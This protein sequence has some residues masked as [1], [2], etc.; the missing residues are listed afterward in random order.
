MLREYLVI[1][2]DIFRPDISWLAIDTKNIIK[3]NKILSKYIEKEEEILSL[4]S[5][6]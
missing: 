6:G 5:E 2:K 1:S 3:K 4:D